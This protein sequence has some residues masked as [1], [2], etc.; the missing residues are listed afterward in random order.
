MWYLIVSIPDLCHLSDCHPSKPAN[1]W[2]ILTV[3]VF[4]PTPHR[5][6][7]KAVIKKKSQNEKDNSYLG[8]EIIK[9]NSR[10]YALSE[11]RFTSI[12]KIIIKKTFIN[13]SYNFLT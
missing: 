3:T 8:L 5:T 12:R 6:K 10:F 7:Y 4:S 11:F 2:F 13:R 9:Q 1:V